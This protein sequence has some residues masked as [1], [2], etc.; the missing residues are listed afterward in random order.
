MIIKENKNIEI[1]IFFKKVYSEETKNN[2]KIV[3][4]DDIMKYGLIGNRKS[5]K[6]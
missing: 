4:K 3:V 6:N 5:K 2:N 1:K